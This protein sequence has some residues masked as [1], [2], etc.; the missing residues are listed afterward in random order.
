MIKQKLDL[1]VKA[2]VDSVICWDPMIIAEVKKRQ[3]PLHISTQASISNSTAAQFY[4]D[5]GAECIVLARECTIKDMVEIKKNVN[6]NLEVFAHGAMCMAVSGR[7]FI[8]QFTTGHSANRGDCKQPCRYDYEL[9]NDTK[10]INI[11]LQ[12]SNFMSPKDLCTMP[13]LDK[14]LLAGADT[15]KIEGR[16]RNPEYVAVTV[17][18][19]RKAIDAFYTNQLTP[20]LQK[21]LTDDLKTVF[22]REFSNGFYMG[23]RISD[24]SKP[25]NFATK[26]KEQVGKILRVYPKINVIEVSLQASSITLGDKLLISGEKCGAYFF[27][28]ESMQ[29]NHQPLKIAPKGINVGIKIDDTTLIRA[30]DE[31]YIL[32]SIFDEK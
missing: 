18:A 28:L 32:K 15:L 10:E 1:A 13:I 27:K 20:Q 4:K 14:L 12:N 11:K 16:A 23:Q 8:S 19:Y 2:K 3:L 30:N 25:G 9:T 7:C 22:N 6:I 26:K 21:K 5:L 24:W 29:A 17:K 31:L